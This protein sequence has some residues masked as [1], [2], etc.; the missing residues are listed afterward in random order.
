MTHRKTPIEK[1]IA[2]PQCE[3]TVQTAFREM[4][5]ALSARG[6]LLD[7]RRAQ[8]ALLATAAKRTASR[9]VFPFGRRQLTSPRSMFSA[10]SMPPSRHS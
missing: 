6:T 9:S 3:L 8:Q 10:R 2:V 5:D 1:N 7:Q 4:S